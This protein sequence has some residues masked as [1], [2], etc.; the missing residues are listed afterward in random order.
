MQCTLTLVVELDAEA[1]VSQMEDAIQAAGRQ[2]MRHAL[3]QAMR[4][5]EATHAMCPHC[6]A[7]SSQSQGTVACRVVTRFAGS[8]WGCGGS[9]AR[10]GGRASFP[11]PAAWACWRVGM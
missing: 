10:A 6:G 11:P 5:Y 1:D 2:A 8:C 7:T 3:Q 4:E 9:G